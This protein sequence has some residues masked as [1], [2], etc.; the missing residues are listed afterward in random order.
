MMLLEIMTRPPSFFDDETHPEAVSAEQR[1]EYMA[2]GYTHY[3]RVAGNPVETLAILRAASLLLAEFAQED[4]DPLEFVGILGGDLIEDAAAQVGIESDG[5]RV[6]AATAA[7]P[8]TPEI[9]LLDQDAAIHARA[10]AMIE[11]IADSAPERLTFLHAAAM[12]QAS[13]ALGQTDPI[14]AAEELLAEHSA[15]TMT[16]TR[17]ALAMRSRQN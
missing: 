3:R 9:T 6:M 2:T 14:G 16:F 7:A 12:L 1:A 5:D 10:W 11:G 4:E 8:T 13:I 15:N 17:D